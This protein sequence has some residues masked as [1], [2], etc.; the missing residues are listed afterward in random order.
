MAGPY[1]SQILPI[2]YTMLTKH[3]PVASF[4]L[5]IDSDVVV[6]GGQ[7]YRDVPNG[8]NYQDATVSLE[9]TLDVSSDDGATWTLVVGGGAAGGVYAYGNGRSIYL[10][11]GSAGG[12]SG[13]TVPAPRLRCTLT[14]SG[15]SASYPLGIVGLIAASHD[16]SFN[17]LPHD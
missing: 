5:V 15:L 2:P 17:F 3:Q 13:L 9:L 1:A 10:T 8:L 7:V 12:I 11:S 6:V 16:S 14:A 4:E